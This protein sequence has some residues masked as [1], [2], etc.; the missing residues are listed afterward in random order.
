VI[1][2]RKF[3][4]SFFLSGITK[5]KNLTEGA[6]RFGGAT[7]YDNGT[8]SNIPGDQYI[9]IQKNNQISIFIPSTKNINQKVNNKKYI[10]YSL[11]YLERFYSIA[12]IN[13]YNTKGSWYSEDK[14]EVIEEDITIMTV[15]KEELTE[16][17]INIFVE[18]ANWI[19]KEMSQE[20]VSIAINSALAI[21]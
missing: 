9:H 13:Y 17:D 8:Y 1:D 15:N 14:N 21:V 6:L 12:Q 11:N 7:K 16:V 5:V 4:F 10:E 2:S 19:K 20:G 18:L 3:N